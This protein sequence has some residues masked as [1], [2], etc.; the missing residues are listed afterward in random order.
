[1]AER[2]TVTTYL[3]TGGG[4]FLGRYVIDELES[5]GV[6]N[7]VVPRRSK[8]DLARQQV[9]EELVKSVQPDVVVHLAA[10]VGGIGAN[11]ENPGRYFYA[12]AIMGINLI[13][14][15]RGTNV[16]KFVQ[17][18]TVCSYPK[19]TDV[20]FVED[21]LWDGYPE[22]TNAPYGVAKR[23]LLVMLQA[24][25]AQYGFN[26]I[27]LL[28]ANLYGP[29]DNFDRQSS[30]VIPA[31]IR[32][33]VE[34]RSTSAKSVTLWGTG[35]PSREFLHVRDAARGIVMASRD[36]DSPKPVNLG[37][38]IETTIEELAQ[39]IVELTGY[40]GEILW[41]ET[42]PDGQPR[43][44]LDVSRSQQEFGFTAETNLK[45]GLRETID[46]WNSRTRESS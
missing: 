8:Y 7:I 1:M 27:F 13:E 35:S 16:A 40:N 44:A 6:E 21:D 46:W 45:V 39:Q 22:E 17:V 41:D 23:A 25:R 24:Y 4:G 43:R 9:A 30:H 5:S 26:G 20:P 34:A 3:V 2:P 12:N 28:P 37:T 32:R 42:K 14:A 18:G 10:E 19:H 31:L 38:G 11:Q 29:H 36:Y 15:A 33:F